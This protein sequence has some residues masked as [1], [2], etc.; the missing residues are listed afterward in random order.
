MLIVL[1]E[2][3]LDL[4]RAPSCHCS[5]WTYMWDYWSRVSGDLESSLILVCWSDPCM[6]V[7][8]SLSLFCGW[9]SPCSLSSYPVPGYICGLNVG[10]PICSWIETKQKGWWLQGPITWRDKD[11]YHSWGPA[12]TLSLRFA[13]LGCSC[14]FC[15]TFFQVA[16]VARNTFHQLHIVRRQQPFL[17]DCNLATIVNVLILLKLD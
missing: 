10:V 7:S 6:C 16:V 11:N 12:P 5:C 15:C 9:T 13:S 1:S 8:L 14:I 3:L 4:T 17:S 2:P